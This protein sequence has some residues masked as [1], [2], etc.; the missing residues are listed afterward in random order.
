MISDA[1]PTTNRQMPG[2]GGGTNTNTDHAPVAATADTQLHVITT[3]LGGMQ[4]GDSARQRKK[5]LRAASQ[6]GLAG[7][8]NLNYEGPPSIPYEMIQF[9]NEE[10]KPIVHPHN[11]AIVLKAQVA[12]NLVKMVLSDN[13]SAADIIF[14]TTLERMK[15]GGL[16]PIPTKTPLFGFTREK[17]MTEGIIDLPVTFETTGG[18]EVV[19]MVLFLVVDQESP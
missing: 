7:Q 15:L 14:K 9:T 4:D 3:I 8:V 10:A 19:Y 1:V 5:L 2:N 12:N 6:E 18:I 13:G 16:R 11:D 17:F